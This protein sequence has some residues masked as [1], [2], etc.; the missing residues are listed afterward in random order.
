ML[1][2]G[3]L[4]LDALRLSANRLASEQWQVDLQSS[5]AAGSLSWRQGSGGSTGQVIARFKY[6]TL[7]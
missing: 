2:W 3:G 5:Q 4:Q 6:L 7:G 1:Q